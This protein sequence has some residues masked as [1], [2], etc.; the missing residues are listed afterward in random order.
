[1]LHPMLIP[2]SFADE[3]HADTE[4]V[5]FEWRQK[6]FEERPLDPKVKRALT[7]AIAPKGTRPKG[8]QIMIY[9]Y[10]IADQV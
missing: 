6:G 8:M 4:T 5:G 10:F 9:G 2:G 3:W 7:V 1:M